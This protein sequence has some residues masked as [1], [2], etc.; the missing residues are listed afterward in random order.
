MGDFSSI[1]CIGKYAA[2]LGQSLSS[3]VETFETKDFSIIED[4]KVKDAAKNTE[5]CFTD[6]IG[7][8]LELNKVLRIKSAN[9]K[10]KTSI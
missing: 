10:I 8:F 7:K 3:S 6:G 1:N 9:H 5:Y 2:R 4:I